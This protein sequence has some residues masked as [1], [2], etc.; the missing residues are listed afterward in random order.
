MKKV[1]IE[2]DDARIDHFTAM[3]YVD[4]VIRGGRVSENNSYC[5]ATIF[6]SDV[7]VYARRTKGGTDVFRV[8]VPPPCPI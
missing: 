8:H 2:F 4:K 3:L 5:A 7:R 6:N 1:S